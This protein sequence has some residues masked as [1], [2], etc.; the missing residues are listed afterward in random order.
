MGIE[1]FSGGF[2]FVDTPPQRLQSIETQIEGEV[3]SSFTE[4]DIDQATHIP[5]H[6]ITWEKARFLFE[7]VG[8]YSLPQ[9]FGMSSDAKLYIGV[10]EYLDNK[11]QSRRKN[12]SL[13][14]S[15]NKPVLFTGTTNGFYAHDPLMA[16]RDEPFYVVGLELADLEEKLTRMAGTYHELG[17]VVLCHSNADTQLFQS[18]LSLQKDDLPKVAKALTYGTELANAIPDHVRN[19]QPRADRQTLFRLSGRYNKI[20]MAKN[21][22]HERNA[23]AAGMKIVRENDYPTG[24]SNPLSYF[25]YARLCLATYARY[26]DEEK[27]VKGL[28]K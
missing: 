16:G 26:H 19:D 23:W 17:H 1:S 27:F 28:R 25:E 21:L 24:Y 22:F 3:E 11:G 12:L 9:R 20:D 4:L 5:L 10:L 14:T 13:T 18:A 8:R 2:G 7:E 15:E 6:D